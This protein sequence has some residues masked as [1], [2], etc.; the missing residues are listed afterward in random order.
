[1]TQQVLNSTSDLLL[2]NEDILPVTQKT[3]KDLAL[4]QSGNETE[5]NGTG[6]KGSSFS[7]EKTSSFIAI[8]SDQKDSGDEEEEAVFSATPKN[9]VSSS[10]SEVTSYC[11]NSTPLEEET[12]PASTAIKTHYD[13]RVNKMTTLPQK[14]PKIPILTRLSSQN[15]IRQ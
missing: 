12:A 5:A 8:I 4:L 3:E 2:R 6:N 13:P 14:S 1:V 7:D 9:T 11:D 10:S 15:V